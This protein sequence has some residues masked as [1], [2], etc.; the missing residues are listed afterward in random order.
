MWRSVLGVECNA[1]RCS[2]YP[3]A[4]THR[5]RRGNKISKWYLQHCTTIHT[6]RRPHNAED[7]DPSGSARLYMYVWATHTVFTDRR[8]KV[9][10]RPHAGSYN[11]LPNTQRKP[12]KS[13]LG[14]PTLSVQALQMVPVRQVQYLRNARPR[15]HIHSS[16]TGW[17]FIWNDQY[18]PPQDRTT[19]VT[20]AI[21]H[22][23]R[24]LTETIIL[25]KNR[26]TKPRRWIDH[27]R[28]RNVRNYPMRKS[29][30][31]AVHLDSTVHPNR[32]TV[33]PKQTNANTILRWC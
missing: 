16:T 9:A 33:S 15:K 26:I 20:A 12:R 11:V 30:W 23:I 2:S 22:R 21:E 6:A 27:E 4:A 1:N 10:D 7:V 19:K 17:N 3:K 24:R 13:M 25:S 14:I 28:D 8:T 29:H 31:K 32:R 5:K 18:L